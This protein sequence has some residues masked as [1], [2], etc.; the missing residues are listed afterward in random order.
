MR[1]YG[2]DFSG[3]HAQWRPQ[4]RKPNVWIATVEGEAGDLRLVKLEPVQALPERFGEHPFDRLVCLLRAG[5]FAAA[6]IDAPFSIPRQYACRF[7]SYAALLDAVEGLPREGRPFPKGAAFVEGL[8]GEK[9]PLA[10]P[11]PMRRTD[12][13]QPRGVNVRSTM[14]NGARG[15]APMTAA[16]M[17]LLARAGRPIWPWAA[18]AQP[19]LLVEAFP[20]A[21]LSTWGLPHQKYEGADNLANRQAIARGLCARLRI[22]KEYLAPMLDCADALD[23]VVCAFAAIAV[24]ED[25]LLNPPDLA[26]CDEEGWIAV[27]V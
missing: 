13:L 9:P 3:N 2:I 15:G 17:A 14:W 6:G 1:W 26:V 24:T 5:D 18:P 19:S 22:P 27:H 7:G 20:A 16:C 25:T 4:T 10:P 21:Q 12:Q 8:T 23:A 11:K